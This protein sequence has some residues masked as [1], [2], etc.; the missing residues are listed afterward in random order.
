MYQRIPEICPPWKA[1]FWGGSSPHSWIFLL[2]PCCTYEVRTQI[3]PLPCMHTCVHAYVCAHTFLFLFPQQLQH[4]FV[5][6]TGWHPLHQAQK[7]R[8]VFRNIPHFK[9]THP[10]SHLLIYLKASWTIF[11]FVVYSPKLPAGGLHFA[12][13]GVQGGSRYV[14]SGWGAGGPI[15]PVT[16]FLGI[17]QLPN[18]TPTCYQTP[19]AKYRCRIGSSH[20]GCPKI[21][22]N[23]P[24]GSLNHSV[25]GEKAY[26]D[27]SLLSVPSCVFLGEPEGEVLLRGRGWALSLHGLH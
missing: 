23:W 12:V 6:E 10:V 4:Y 21:S 14:P 19:L 15:M 27:S 7:V 17:P 13:P 2:L 5:G 3:L 24:T 11:Y 20:I 16:L 8:D 18:P 26:M 9:M 1:V 22:K 25:P